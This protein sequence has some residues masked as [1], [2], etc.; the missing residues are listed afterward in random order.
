MNRFRM[1]LLVLSLLVT[2]PLVGQESLPRAPQKRQDLWQ[3]LEKALPEEFREIDVYAE[4]DA[5]T[6][7]LF[8]SQGKTFVF[9]VETGKVTQLDHMKFLRR[10]NRITYT[11]GTFS[12]W[13][14]GRVELN[15]G[16]E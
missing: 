11:S 5:L 2:A 12:L 6:R 1:C 13:Y 3:A 4:T 16:A 8:R 7:V 9:S 10:V 14:N 15:I